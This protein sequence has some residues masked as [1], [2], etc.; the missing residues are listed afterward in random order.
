M[1]WI[2]TP[3]C[4]MAFP[5]GEPRNA[6]PANVARPFALYGKKSFSFKLGGCGARAVDILP[7]SAARA[8]PTKRIPIV[9]RKIA[10]PN[11]RLC[12]DMA[13]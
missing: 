7:G 6:C 8:L 10:A 12:N 11:S 13:L 3:A 5:D 1:R 9:S 4:V 2:G